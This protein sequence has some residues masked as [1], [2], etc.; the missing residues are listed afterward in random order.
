MDAPGGAAGNGEL[1]IGVDLGTGGVRVVAT[2]AAGEV[3]ARAEAALP[4][5]PTV[6]AVGTHEQDPLDWW[7]ATCQALSELC[8]RLDLA[9]IRPQQLRGLAVDGTSG[10]LVCLDGDGAPV[11]PA[12]MYND[13]RA[14]D[15]AAQVTELAGD[16]CRRLGYRFEASFALAK[17]VWIQRNE[18]ATY[19][20]ADRFVHQA[21][22]VQG[23][24][25]GDFGVSDY[26]NALKTGYD[27]EAECWPP[28]MAGLGGVAERLPRVVPPGTPVGQ[29]SAVAAPDTG[30]PAGLA[31]VTGATDGTTACLASGVRRP[32]DYNTT[33]GTTLVFKG[34][35]R[36]LSRHPQGLVYSHKL[37]GGYWLPGAASNTGGEWIAAL[38]PG[39]DP[40]S[41]DAAAA[42][43]LPSSCIAYPLARRGER[44]PFL[45]ESAEGFCVPEPGSRAELYAAHLQGVAL[46]ERLGYQVLDQVSGTTGGEVFSTGG[47]SRSDVW[48]Q[49]RADATGRSMHRPAAPD[50][51]FGSAVL[52]AAGV[53]Y[54]D[55]WQ[56]VREMVRI[57]KTVDPDPGRV[58]R[59]DGL[60]QRF[61]AEL[62]ERGCG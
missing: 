38:F 42:S 22:Y 27:L 29:V 39:E 17:I 4:P 41:L 2:Q 7:D 35:S 25:T 49:C 10:T 48:L 32:G 54:G 45:S 26:S 16:F 33:L 21:D 40:A 44:F 28:W 13:A 34:I 52:A 31:V 43:L 5:T 55:V 14:R 30:L 9:G 59:Y 57:E 24:L 20:R 23:R 56:A 50:S 11:R 62:A 46:V 1:F 51:A 3:V 36:H 37:P 61:R 60:F 58:P 47:G 12:M 8:R 53:L 18:P 6:A 19:A 15:E